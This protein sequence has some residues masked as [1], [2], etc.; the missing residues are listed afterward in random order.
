MSSFR[1]WAI[2]NGV[3]IS[4]VTFA[5]VYVGCNHLFPR[6]T[7]EYLQQKAAIEIFR[8]TIHDELVEIA[9]TRERIDLE[10][11]NIN[12]YKKTNKFGEIGYDFNS[13]SSYL[14]LE[15]HR[16]LALSNKKS[17]TAKLMQG[18]YVQGL[19][20]ALDIFEEAQQMQRR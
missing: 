10:L 14:I 13:L 11:F 5:F 17:A 6:P 7:S 16:D 15:G 1:R 12:K 20:M 4:F 18:G 2:N 3:A 19:Q 8:D 9:L